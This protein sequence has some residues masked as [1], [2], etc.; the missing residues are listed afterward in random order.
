M[1]A[2][3]HVPV[4]INAL[5]G[6]RK[7]MLNLAAGE[8]TQTG[9]ILVR[10]NVFHQH[11]TRVD[12]SDTPARQADCRERVTTASGQTVY[13]QTYRMRYVD[14]DSGIVHLQP[15]AGKFEAAM[16]DVIVYHDGI[17]YICIAGS[18]W[19]C[20]LPCIPVPV[21]PVEPLDPDSSRRG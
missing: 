13:Q 1:G 4:A 5:Q 9:S 3:L 15:Y 16:P 6:G 14:G 7:S 19:W 10:A 17:C 21:G 20:G 18:A 12:G 2:G 11:L 8:E